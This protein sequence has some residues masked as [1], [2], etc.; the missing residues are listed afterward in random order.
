MD[1]NDIL[2][3]NNPHYRLF[4]ETVGVADNDMLGPDPSPTRL[5]S[6]YSSMRLKGA[7][8][9]DPDF[10]WYVKAAVQYDL[11][12]LGAMRDEP[13]LFEETEYFKRISGSGEGKLVT[14]WHWIM[15]KDPQKAM[16]GAQRTGDCVSSG[17]L[18]TCCG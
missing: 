3:I 6:L 1:V 13:L 18:P 17:V 10:P 14:P 4:S 9:D 5:W 2:G 11:D 7:I 12:A 15:R 8:V 16:R